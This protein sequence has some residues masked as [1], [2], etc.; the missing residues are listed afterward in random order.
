M[1]DFA[2]MGPI[3]EYTVRSLPVSGVGDDPL[4][5]AQVSGFYGPGTWSAWYSTIIAAWIQLL[6]QPKRTLDPN[7][8][9]YILGMNWAAIDLFRQV[10][11]LRTAQEQGHSLDLR[12]KFMGPIAAPYMIVFWGSV[13]AVLQNVVAFFATVLIITTDKKTKDEI[14]IEDLRAWFRVLFSR[15]L[16]LSMG[17]I[18]PLT[19]LSVLFFN[20]PLQE[21]FP[22]EE[23]HYMFFPA[24]YWEGIRGEHVTSVFFAGWG[25]LALLP[26]FLVYTILI[27][28][29][30]TEGCFRLVIAFLHPPIARMQS[31]VAS[32][33]SLLG[34]SLLLSIMVLWLHTFLLLFKRPLFVLAFGLFGLLFLCQFIVGIFMLLGIIGFFFIPSA[35]LHYFFYILRGT[36]VSESCFLMPCAP[37]SIYDWDQAFSLTAGLILLV[38]TEIVPGVRKGVRLFKRLR[39]RKESILEF[40]LGDLNA[41]KPEEVEMANLEAGLGSGSNQE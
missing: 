37:Q 28:L 29:P 2:F 16:V 7:S 19:A 35:V 21:D 11:S 12:K 9:F 27:L 24:L 1:A 20:P 30:I 40:P 25:G 36:K 5:I 38:F 15:R 18:L 14:D 3:I 26:I 31:L 22:K 41:A 23:E 39:E 8:W 17:L 34:R 4:G 33:S 13:H 32:I 6:V 10:H